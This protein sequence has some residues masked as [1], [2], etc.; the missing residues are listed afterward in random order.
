MFIRAYSALS[1]ARMK[2]D[3]LDAKGG[4]ILEKARIVQR[5]IGSRRK[6]SS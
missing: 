1:T 4:T 2:N 6:Y 5:I 3:P